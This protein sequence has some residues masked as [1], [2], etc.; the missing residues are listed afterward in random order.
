[1]IFG[2]M[3]RLWTFVLAHAGGVQASP[4]DI[5]PPHDADGTCL[6]RPY[7]AWARATVPGCSYMLG[8]VL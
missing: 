7:G 4:S 5:Q 3:R 2:F 6:D 1:M 8:E